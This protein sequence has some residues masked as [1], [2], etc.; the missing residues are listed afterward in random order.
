MF[1]R[2]SFSDSGSQ[3]TNEG[4]NILTIIIGAMLQLAGALLV[5]AFIHLTLNVQPRL[6][7]GYH[8]GRKTALAHMPLGKS[9]LLFGIGLITIFTV[10]VALFCLGSSMI[11]TTLGYGLGLGLG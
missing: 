5:A 11:A 2:V 4:I 10:G 8:S 1:E 9:H 6:F 7:P 3:P